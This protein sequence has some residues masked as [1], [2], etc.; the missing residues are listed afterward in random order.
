MGLKLI[1]KSVALFFIYS[2]NVYAFG[3]FN[4]EK[5][6]S[7]ESLVIPTKTVDNP[8]ENMSYENINTLREYSGLKDVL[9]KSN[10]KL[11]SESQQFIKD[12]LSSLE[13]QLE[14][15]GLDANELYRVRSEITEMN[16]RNIYSPNP[17]VIDK[18]W[19]IGGYL[20][21]ID[22]DG[23]KV[24]RFFLVPIAGQC[25]HTPAPAANQI[26]LVTYDDGIAM[27]SLEDPLWISGKLETELNTDNATYYD[28]INKVESLYQ[29]DAENVE[30]MAK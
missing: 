20:V 22:M 28:G 6:L 7:W 26:I 18:N 23:M 27:N 14:K 17:Q 25:I 11:D 3:I 24:T 12:K 5:Q 15:Q 30:Y 16:R 1:M 2:V 13:S 8:F 21:P 4:D 10:V 19:I 29:M 9:N